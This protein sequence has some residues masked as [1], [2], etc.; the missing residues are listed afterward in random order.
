[1][2]GE[3]ELQAWTDTSVRVSEQIG[4]QGEA[5]DFCGASFEWSR[6]LVNAYDGN[7]LDS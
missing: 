4:K 1:M 3:G 2:I 5:G 7:G 6:R